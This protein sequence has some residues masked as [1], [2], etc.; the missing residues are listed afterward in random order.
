MVLGA[1]AIDAPFRYSNHRHLVSIVT[2]VAVLGASGCGGSKARTTSTNSQLRPAPPYRV[3]QFCSKAR[4]AQYVRAGFAC[5][6][7]HLKK[8]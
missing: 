3:G 8:R 5:S 7:K 2:L 1:T 6:H 4:Q